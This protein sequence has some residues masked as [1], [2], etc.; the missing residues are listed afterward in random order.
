ME[1]AK[2][3]KSSCS[4]I[5][6]RALRAGIFRCVGAGIDAVR[7]FFYPMPDSLRF[8][9]PPPPKKGGSGKGLRWGGKRK[10]DSQIDSSSGDNATTATAPPAPQNVEDPCMF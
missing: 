6:L 4:I 7:E 9:P 10:S 2:K 5:P 8:G 1:S 3:R